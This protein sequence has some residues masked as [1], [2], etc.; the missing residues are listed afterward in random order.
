MNN[1][2]TVWDP[3]VRLFHWLL[4]AAF[5]AMM[6]ED[7]DAFDNFPAPENVA[8]FEADPRFQVL[9]G[10]TEGET[11]LSINNAQSPAE[12]LAALKIARSHLPQEQVDELVQL[13]ITKFSAASK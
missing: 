9:V 8:Q 10:S 12:G 5:A 2:V 13:N 4:V 6:A 3:L 7:I 1:R 11:I